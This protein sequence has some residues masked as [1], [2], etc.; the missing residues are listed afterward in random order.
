MQR[1]PDAVLQKL[2]QQGKG[3]SQNEEEG[4]ARG[5]Q[6]RGDSGCATTSETPFSFSKDSPHTTF[7]S[8]SPSFGGNA[9][10]HSRLPGSEVS[11]GRRGEPGGLAI[12]AQVSL[13]IPPPPRPSVGSRA[14]TAPSGTPAAETVSP[15][16]LGGHV[17]TDAGVLKS[18]FNAPT[19]PSIDSSKI[20]RRSTGSVSTQPMLSPHWTSRC[21]KSAISLWF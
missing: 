3:Q 10:G 11:R 1:L 16:L 17:E 4:G 2:Q 8:P 19:T 15:Q 5:G 9:T 13:T 7:S 18:K 14:P 6:S 21:V 12:S 20:L